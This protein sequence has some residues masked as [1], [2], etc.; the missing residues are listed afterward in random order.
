MSRP[1][2]SVL[3][4][5]TANRSCSPAALAIARTIASQRDLRW[6]HLDAAGTAPASRGD[7]A[8]PLSASEGARRGYRVD[9]RTRPV[10]PDDFAEFDLI[11]A[12]RQTEIDDLRRLGGTTDQR[13]GPYGTFEPHQ[14]QLLRR[15]DPFGMPGDEELAVPDGGGAA[16]VAA[17]YDVLERSIPPLLDHTAW[18]T[19]DILRDAP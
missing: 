3:F 7:V 5:C 6:L 9:H 18:L 11:V 4:V 2:I 10:H 19:D 17:M 16:A 12:M 8:D 13:I 15:W 1:A 14:L